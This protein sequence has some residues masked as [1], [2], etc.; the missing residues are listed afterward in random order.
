MRTVTNLNG[1]GRCPKCG[2]TLDYGDS[3]AEDDSFWY[4]CWCSDEE[5][6]WNGEEC[7]GLHF[8]DYCENEDQNQEVNNARTN[9]GTKS[10][11]QWDGKNNS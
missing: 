2:S 7:Y 4:E 1:I 9:S 6:G 3:E 11:T 10:P 8:I 5:C